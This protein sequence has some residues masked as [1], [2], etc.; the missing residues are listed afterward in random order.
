M[1]LILLEALGAGLLL[2]FIVWW[3]M[4]SGRPLD[5]P[6]EPPAPPQ[7]PDTAGAAQPLAL[8]TAET[9]QQSSGAVADRAASGG[10]SAGAEGT[11]TPP[12]PDPR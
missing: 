2:V 1:T 5:P 12:T 6:A 8:G 7:P 10:D 11:P 3:T 4:F 9:P